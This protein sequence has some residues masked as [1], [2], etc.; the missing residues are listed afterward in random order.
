VKRGSRLFVQALSSPEP[1]PLRATANTSEAVE[2]AAPL[3][4]HYQIDATRYWLDVS[5]PGRLPITYRLEPDGALPDWHFLS[6]GGGG[7]YCHG[8]HDPL[9]RRSVRST[10]ISAD[11]KFAFS[12]G[13]EGLLLH[14][15][16][17]GEVARYADTPTRRIRWHPSEARVAYI[18]G[19][20]RSEPGIL[21]LLDARS[22]A[23]SRW[24]VGVSEFSWSPDGRYLAVVRDAGGRRPCAMELLLLDARGTSEPALWVTCGLFEQGDHASIDWSR[25]S[26]WLAYR[27]LQ[28]DRVGLFHPKTGR[29]YEL[30]GFQLGRDGWAV[31]GDVMTSTSRSVVWLQAP[32]GPLQF[33]IDSIFGGKLSPKG[34][35]FTACDD[36]SLLLI[37]ARRPKHGYRIGDGRVSEFSPDG[38][39]LAYAENHRLYV[40][41]LRNPPGAPQLIAAWEEPLG[42][43]DSVTAGTLGLNALWAPRGEHLVFAR[44][45]NG[46]V[47]LELASL[48]RGWRPIVLATHLGDNIG[49][50]Y[51]RPQQLTLLPPGIESVARGL[52]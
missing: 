51:W 29:H 48:Q 49:R 6:S 44:R 19:E 9:P 47:Q 18:D 32:A 3:W 38:E 15:V 1:R 28:P 39:W 25:D 7:T 36:E 4:F 2:S 33:T 24:M 46:Q 21:T 12:V 11:G 35:F 16:A 22:R 10:E 52:D 20:S 34:F 41:R 37:D 27:H 5:H 43:R 31:N 17:S 8:D 42:V 30:E 26:S 14:D 50:R 45:L 23:Q 13:W 40:R